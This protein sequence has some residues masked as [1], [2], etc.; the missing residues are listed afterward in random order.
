M[1]AALESVAQQFSDEFIGKND[2]GDVKKQLI[3]LRT[4]FQSGAY[5]CRVWSSTKIA[6]TPYA[7]IN[8]ELEI[9][10]S[11]LD[12]AVPK[13]LYLRVALSSGGSASA[14]CGLA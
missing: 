3:Q 13:D 5:L 6:N 4:I 9:L 1:Q 11:A 2:D 12:N 10:N 8:D 14:S 7:V